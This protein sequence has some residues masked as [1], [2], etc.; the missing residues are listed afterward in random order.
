[1]V[2][3]NLRDNEGNC[4]EQAA[5]ILN[6]IAHLSGQLSAVARGCRTKAEADAFIEAS[7]AHAVLARTVLA[8]VTDALARERKFN[9]NFAS[10]PR[11]PGGQPEGGRWTDGGSGGPSSRIRYVQLQSRAPVSADDGRGNW[12]DPWP[13][14]PVPV[15]FRNEI[16][17]RESGGRG[18]HGYSAIYRPRGE[19]PVLGRYQ[20][21]GPA[22]IQ[23]GLRYADG[24]WNAEN[25]YGARTEQEFLNNP[26]AQERALAAYL[27]DNE[28]QLQQR[29]AYSFIGREFIGMSGERIT[30]TEAG[31]AAAAHR[32]GAP[33]VIGYLRDLQSRNSESNAWRAYREGLTP[34]QIERY[35]ELEARLREFEH[36]RYARL[37]LI[38]H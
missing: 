38:P 4:R 23:I 9:P 8:S 24:S 31:L 11:V 6:R 16:A 28:R 17:A 33:R 30:I 20:L 25:P 35:N 1:M 10:Q 15:E 21:A 14:S 36:A 26:A 2:S 29:G 37:R 22:Q 32:A 34:A 13:G 3:P 27:S 18:N 5:S 7:A 12:R 19:L